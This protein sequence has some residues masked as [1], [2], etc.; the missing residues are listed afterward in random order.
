MQK[1]QD[2][3]RVGLGLGIS[4]VVFACN[5]VSGSAPVPLQPSP[6]SAVPLSQPTGIVS[7]DTPTVTHVVRPADMVPSGARVVDVDSRPTAPEGRAPYG[8][9][10]QINRLE[11]PFLQNMSF[12]PGLDLQTYEVGG[13]AN[14]WYVTLTLAGP[15]PDPATAP[16]YG[17]ELDLDHDGF[18]DYLIWA[19]P[20]YPAAW[21]SSPVEIFQD[22]NHDTGGLSGERSDAPISTDGYETRIFNGGNGD[23]DPDMAWVRLIPSGQPNVQFAF[24]KS[25]SGVVFMLGVLADSGLLDPGKLDYVDRFTA[26]EA[27]SPVRN[28]SNYPLKAL[29][30]IDNIC[31][32]AFGFR[33][34]GYEPQLCPRVEPTK[35]P[36]APTEVAGCSNEPC[37]PDVGIWHGYPSCYCDE[38]PR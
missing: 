3:T 30:E 37:G 11:R 29:Y 15:N 7:T 32:E 21:D 34:T 5:L 20:P 23:S 31:R 28:N 10:F 9:S 1:R 13:D 36:R 18:G 26:E 33:A 14:W 4:F 12:V 38:W 25:W 2:F 16:N 17:V 24:K 27:G 35:K 22:K 19:H 8:D 6:I